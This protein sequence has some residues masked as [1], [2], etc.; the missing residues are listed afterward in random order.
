MSGRHQQVNLIWKGSDNCEKITNYYYNSENRSSSKNQL[1][2]NI[3]YDILI[4]L[5]AVN[6]TDRNKS[7]NLLTC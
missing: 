3:K 5:K 1:K 4:L 6:R 2:N 7:A